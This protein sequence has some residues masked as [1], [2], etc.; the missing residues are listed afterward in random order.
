MNRND[1]AQPVLLAVICSCL[2]SLAGMAQR[3]II[4][5]A[6][7]GGDFTDI[8]PAVDAAK[9]GDT[10]RIE[11]GIYSGATITKSLKLL[12]VPPDHDEDFQEVIVQGEILVKDLGPGEAFV[13]ADL[14][15]QDFKAG[16]G[17][18]SIGNFRFEDCQGSIY[19]SF[20]GGD[21]T[22]NNC[23]YVAMHRCDSGVWRFTDAKVVASRCDVIGSPL[24]LV[25]ERSDITLIAGGIS[26]FVPI[27]GG[28]EF[29]SVRLVDSLVTQ[30][31][32]SFVRGSGCFLPTCNPFVLEGNSK[33]SQW[34]ASS[35]AINDTLTDR[36]ITQLHVSDPSAIVAL[37]ASLGGAPVSLAEGELYVDL[38]TFQFLYFGPVQGVGVGGP[39]ARGTAFLPTAA[40]PSRHNTRSLQQAMPMRPDAR[41]LG[42]PVTFQA[43]VLENNKLRLSLP[44][45]VIL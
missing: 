18:P 40:I 29:P 44:Y 11:W 13:A 43:L 39:E 17:G 31:E 32:G 20:L 45:T 30:A 35:I 6:A 24:G 21:V 7:G 23:A 38:S 26:S 34:D 15:V 41:L 3:T 4:V 37:G 14:G 5:D 28:G 19:M 1:K 27:P 33:V 2:L 10:I 12:G 36:L 22:L 8:Q 9:R 42:I 16:F 25:A